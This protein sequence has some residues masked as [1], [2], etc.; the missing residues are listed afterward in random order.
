M[1]ITKLFVSNGTP[2]AAYLT[3]NDESYPV[4]LEALGN[5]VILPALIASG[6]KLTALPLT[7]NKN[8]I[9]L[10]SLPKEEWSTEL[11]SK[12]GQDMYDMLGTPMPMDDRRKLLYHGTTSQTFPEMPSYKIN[13]REEFYAYLDSIKDGVP[14][15]DY[16]PLNCI[17]HPNARLS[18]DEYIKGDKYSAIIDFR[19]KLSYTRYTRLCRFLQKHGMPEKFTDN[20]FLKAYMQWGVDGL[21]F[22]YK[23]TPG[24]SSVPNRHDYNLEWS[25]VTNMMEPVEIHTYATRIVYAI[26]VRT[27]SSMTVIPPKGYTEDQLFDN[28][29]LP[30]YD[31]EI[32]N[33][34]CHFHLSADEDAMFRTLPLGGALVVKRKVV[35][36]GHQWEC[37][38]EH[39]I[40][41]I[42]AKFENFKFGD[43]LTAPGIS[44]S[45]PSGS[46][47]PTS[48]IG[49]DDAVRT[50]GFAMAISQ[51]IA[52]R[53]KT[54]TNSSLYKALRVNGYSEYSALMYF[55]NTNKYYDAENPAMLTGGDD[56]E[57][58]PVLTADMVKTY[59]SAKMDPDHYDEIIAGMP[60]YVT[61]NSS[62]SEVISMV[63]DTLDGVLDGSTNNARLDKAYEE[64]SRV[65]AML[66]Y[67]SLRAVTLCTDTTIDD[68][69]NQLKHWEPGT[70]VVVK[71]DGGQ[72]TMNG[73]KFD[74]VQR[75]YDN[76]V[77]IIRYEHVNKAPYFVWVEGAIK[78]FGDRSR[79]KHIGFFGTVLEV[80]KKPATAA[81][82]AF[83][84]FYAS[85]VMEDLEPLRL[86]DPVK[87]ERIAYSYLHTPG[88]S[89]MAPEALD[90]TPYGADVRRKGVAQFSAA[91]MLMQAIR[92]GTFRL[93]TPKN[94]NTLVYLNEHP[95]LQDLVEKAKKCMVNNGKYLYSDCKSFADKLIDDSPFPL[96]PFFYTVN[97]VVSP[98]QVHPRKNCTVGV[99]D[100]VCCYNY[101][102]FA[103]LYANDER[104][105]LL[106]GPR[107]TVFY[108]KA[109]FRSDD[110][111]RD[112]LTATLDRDGV[113]TNL[114]AYYDTVLSLAK[115]WKE[116][117]ST[118]KLA[119]FSGSW[120]MPN[121]EPIDGFEPITDNS[122]MPCFKPGGWGSYSLEFVQDS[123]YIEEVVRDVH[124][125][126]GVSCD[127][128]AAGVSTFE[129]PAV[130]GHSGMLMLQGNSIYASIYGQSGDLTEL[131][132][133][134]IANLDPS[135]YPV[136]H[137]YGARYV[138]R[139]VDGKLYYVE[140]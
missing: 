128:Y 38:C 71:F 33:P 136:K 8:G 50:S 31:F 116:E 76:Q 81:L 114:P 120:D 59:L 17:V 108:R 55:I 41:H 80:G 86:S 112:L 100:P 56:G 115:A 90:D 103:E 42:I 58:F 15:S 117:G 130:V 125:F 77:R 84:D 39:A 94:R 135:V 11:E 82:A 12:Y 25:S 4:L 54:N 45:T 131:N 137:L 138:F 40:G 16:L 101:S 88:V 53:R 132:A 129:P 92:Q 30:K 99:F 7:L 93:N 133:S 95:V 26:C 107:D 124:P 63:C 24:I 46:P 19:R 91:V 3:D 57:S 18:I 29:H 111:S 83:A 73:A 89:T 121:I 67:H 74:M 72:I 9:D 28:E 20:D 97:A 140:V 21:Q 109:E 60:V 27:Q 87:Y 36:P 65:N 113:T 75:E 126:T 51:M 2:Y 23:G 10:M 118:T 68:I 35:H 98:D 106:P 37:A 61:G 96:A 47:M 13:T 122:G 105:S 5:E 69:Y 66:Y 123:V 110:G 64:E 48:L 52:D 22:S 78:E 134:D 6:W 34:K 62:R 85:K 14:D 104:K 49:D 79:D 119:G 102:T 70:P 44:I 139:T 32:P 43:A 127:E 1:N